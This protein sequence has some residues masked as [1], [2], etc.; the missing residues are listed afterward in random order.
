MPPTS[1][2]DA[3]FAGLKVVDLSQGIAGPYCGMLLAQHGANVIKVEPVES[4]GDW[5]RILG[6]VYGDHTAFSIPGNLG[7]R[8]I[9][10]DL[11]SADGKAVLWRLLDDAD[12][13]MEGFRPGVIRRLGFD[14]ETVAARN[15]RILYLSVSGFGQSG[16]LSER[17]AMDPVLQAYT[18]LIMENK[19][20]DGVP[21]R[22]PYI[23]VDMATALYAFQ[24]LAPAIHA[25]QRLDHGRYIETSLMQAAAGMQVVR[26][27]G[28]YLEDGAEPVASVPG[29]SFK[30]ADG[31]MQIAV[32]QQRDWV[33]LCAAID[34]P[35]L[36]AD[37]L[38]DTRERR[39]RNAD[40]LYAIIRPAFAAMTCAD[41]DARLA[42][43]GIMHERLNSYLEFLK[44][45]HVEQTGLIAWL[46]QTGLD[47]AAPVPNLPGPP[48]LESGTPRAT[49][50]TWGQHTEEVLREHGYAPAE[51]AELAARGVVRLPQAL[52]KKAS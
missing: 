30:T 11:K 41:L 15:K 33:A 27:M 21:H 28:T 44:Q 45:P 8:S 29:G 43:A 23:A 14:Y 31:W 24:A 48:A 38:F 17:P 4:G 2:Y 1:G 37:P 26:M 22:V 36:A 3:P 34:L 12:V 5:T 35:D 13:M 9:A 19:G 10:L 39:I 20:T 18:G 6:H 7:K 51:I 46:D 49:A 52:H 16:P 25:R 47:R 40:A 32:V 50:P 42:K